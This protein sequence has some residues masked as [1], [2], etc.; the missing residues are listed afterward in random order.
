MRFI[1]RVIAGFL[2]YT[3]K[4]IVGRVAQRYIAGETLEDAIRV[5]RGLNIKG[6]RATMD[7]LGEDIHRID[8][9]R[10]AA[11]NYRHLL[12][13]LA[14]QKVDSTV[15]VKLTQL[16]LKVDKDECLHLADSVV[17]QAFVHGNFVRI[18]MEDSSCTSDTLDLYV[19]LRRRHE[20][21][22]VVLQAYLRR[23]ASDVERLIAELHPLEPNIRLCKG[24]YVEP[25]SIAY[26]DMAEINRNYLMLLERFLRSGIYVGIATHDEH[27]V[28]KAQRM[29]AEL[30]PTPEAYEFQM[31]LG[32]AEALR[33]RIRRAGH[34][35]RVYIPFGRDWYAYSVRRLRENPRLAGYV[36]RAMF[37]R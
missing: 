16:G 6:F 9:A 1:D 23:T 15:S 12:D 5:A 30:R 3:P 14:R 2:P 37:R 20:N 10:T 32:V 34:P 17:A 4:A 27:L 26:H 11:K 29:I 21:V 28:A 33:D 19:E 18:D 31:L 22:G 8:Q 25:E 13:E 7:I 35:L 24:V 36:L